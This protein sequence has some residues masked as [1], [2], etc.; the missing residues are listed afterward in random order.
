[1]KWVIFLKHISINNSA[2][3]N[4]RPLPPN[5]PGATPH[6]GLLTHSGLDIWRDWQYKIFS[7]P[8]APS[9]SGKPAVVSSCRQIYFWGS[10]NNVGMGRRLLLF[11]EAEWKC[12]WGSIIQPHWHYQQWL[13]YFHGVWEMKARAGVHRRLVWPKLAYLFPGKLWLLLI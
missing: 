9:A 8:K 13:F 6:Q 11:T 1:M 7:P 10:L 3:N 5:F 12:L 4:S 2:D